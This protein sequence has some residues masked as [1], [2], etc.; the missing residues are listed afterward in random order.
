MPTRARFLSLST[1]AAAAT[2]GLVTTLASMTWASRADAA[3]IRPIPVEKGAV[4][5]DG[6]VKE[7]AVRWEQLERT[8]KGRAFGKGE[9]EASL[10]YDA[11]NLYLALRVPD[12]KI[13]RRKKP[14]RKQDH[15][16]I[17]LAFP[18]RGGGYVTETVRVY[19]GKPAKIAGTVRVNGRPVKGS[20]TVEA[21]NRRGFTME[22]RIP[23]SAFGKHAQARV[24]MRAAIRY[25]DASA[26][27]HV[28]R[29]IATHSAT[30]GRKLPPLRFAAE[31]AVAEHVKQNS[32]S[33]VAGEPR[34]AQIAPGKS[35]E[36]VAAYGNTIT[37]IGPD[38]MNGRG[39]TFGELRGTTERFEFRDFT[40]DGLDEVVAWSRSGT[41]EEFRESFQVLQIRSGQ[42]VSVFEHETKV[43]TADGSVAN[44]IVFSKSDKSA[45]QIVAT[46]AS[47]YEQSNPVPRPKHGA[48]RVLQ[49]W[50][51]R[52]K[53]FRW[54]ESRFVLTAE[55]KVK[56]KPPPPSLRAP[57]RKPTPKSKP[58]RA[59][60]SA[61]IAQVIARFRAAEGLAST[62]LRHDLTANLFG[63]PESERVIVA[64]T[65]L[66]VGGVDLNGGPGYAF[67]RVNAESAEDIS[68]PSFFDVTGDNRSEVILRVA[69]RLSTDTGDAATREIYLVYQVTRGGLRRLFGAE[70]SRTLGSAR[71][72]T[73]VA[74]KPRKASRTK[75][76]TKSRKNGQKKGQALDLHVQPYKPK[77]WSESTYPFALAEDPNIEPLLLPW[78]PS[79]LRV[80]RFDGEAFKYHADFGRRGRKLKKR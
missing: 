18:K 72:K 42:L 8:V 60:A 76:R 61:L 25:V 37:A 62:P 66:A 55:D 67:V 65:R 20:R 3:P 78:E 24:G 59:N 12:Q 19:P 17:Y 77:G 5:I 68:K 14:D 23:W 43:V 48:P 10:G 51:Y 13:A 53:T 29:I 16:V 35:L 58:K 45:F 2:L 27:G 41:Q 33:R 46:R 73:R 4:R 52:S 22:T 74:F 56:P 71:L 32:L 50:Q 40:G 47:G 80:Y 69:Q 63:G 44:K 64:G 1:T 70:V 49:P 21:P 54:D 38:I 26:P 75:S 28:Q 39:M 36:F 6:V 31:N 57:A 34:L 79:K 30:K 11:T 7:W 15:A 9:A